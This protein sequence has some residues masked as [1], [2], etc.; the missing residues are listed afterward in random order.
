ML[1]GKVLASVK[2]YFIIFPLESRIEIELLFTRIDYAEL[3]FE[4]FY[5]I[6]YVLGEKQV[7]LE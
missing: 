6:M 1:R 3:G 7:D 2:T 5:R 4:D